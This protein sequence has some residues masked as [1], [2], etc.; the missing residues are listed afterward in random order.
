MR[1]SAAVFTLVLA[2]LAS[3]A[4]VVTTADAN[5]KVTRLNELDIMVQ[6]AAETGSIQLHFAG[7]ERIDHGTSGDLLI[8]KGGGGGRAYYHPDIYQLIDGKV[9]S[10]RVSY[11]LNGPDR[12]TM[13]FLNFKKEAPLILRRGAATF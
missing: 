13:S 9:K 4:E 1:T 10:V 8:F 6:C 11:K 3:A 12:A 5:T 7:A 2:S